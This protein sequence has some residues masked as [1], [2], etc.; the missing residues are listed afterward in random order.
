MI[1]RLLGS[2]IVFATVAI[3]AGAATRV[4]AN[5]IE[6]GRSEI[7]NHDE[8]D[9]RP[10]RDD[11]NQQCR[12]YDGQ[13]WRCEE[14]FGCTYDHRFGV[15]ENLRFPDRN[16]HSFCQQFDGR[17]HRCE[18]TRDCFFD[19]H[20]GTCEDRFGRDDHWP[21]D[22]GGEARSCDSYSS[23]PA[24]CDNQRNCYF[25]WRFDACLER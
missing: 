16:R 19:Y 1:K 8:N 7:L 12:W 20:R 4:A 22:P 11:H 5:G 3:G 9:H 13:P 25:D 18:S 21:R 14:I 2:F 6:V 17:P 23:S 15:C 24:L 10:P